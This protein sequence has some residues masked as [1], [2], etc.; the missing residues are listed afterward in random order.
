V[1]TRGSFFAAMS[2]SNTRTLP[3]L[4]GNP[5]EERIARTACVSQ[6]ADR[7]ADIETRMSSCS[8][9]RDRDRPAV[10]VPDHKKRIGCLYGFADNPVKRDMGAAK[11]GPVE[12][13]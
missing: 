4:Y 1:V 10:P 13:G 12:L 9:R 5:R 8:L 11:S 7:E 2:A 6:S 3:R